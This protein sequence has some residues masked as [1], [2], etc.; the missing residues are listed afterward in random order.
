M[1]KAP[2]ST[3]KNTYEVC[4][5]GADGR[6]SEKLEVEGTSAVSAGLGQLTIYDG[7]EIVASFANTTSWRKI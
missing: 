3:A 4:I 2:T 7:E 6:P 5:Q 1:A